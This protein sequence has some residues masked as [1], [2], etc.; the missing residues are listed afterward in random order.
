MGQPRVGDERYPELLRHPSRSVNHS[1]LEPAAACW[2][3]PNTLRFDDPETDCAADALAA[4]ERT[5][6]HPERVA[7][8][9]AA[10]EGPGMQI[11]VRG[12]SG[13]AWEL[14]AHCRAYFEELATTGP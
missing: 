3:A 10:L 7:E 2:R 11:E 1:T 12:E 5:H 6:E 9:C 8:R 13:R 4:S 14:F